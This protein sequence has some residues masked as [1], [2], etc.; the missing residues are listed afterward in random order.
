MTII[1]YLSDTGDKSF[2][3]SGFLHIYTKKFT[4]HGRRFYFHT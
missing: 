2:S 1:D 4:Q 3:E